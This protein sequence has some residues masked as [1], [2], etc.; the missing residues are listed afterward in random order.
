MS[1]SPGGSGGRNGRRRERREPAAADGRERS[2]RR[3]RV[4]RAGVQRTGWRRGASALP[5]P[6][7]VSPRA[8]GRWCVR[9]GGRQEIIRCS[10]AADHEQR[11]RTPADRIPLARRRCRRLRAPLAAAGHRAARERRTAR[12]S[13]A[14]GRRAAR[15][16]PAPSSLGPRVRIGLQH[17]LEQR[18]DAQVD[19]AEIGHLA[20]LLDRPRPGCRPCRS[21][22]RSALRPA[23]GRGCRCRT[24]P[25]R[26]RRTG[27]AARARHSCTCRQ[28]R[29]R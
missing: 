6:E 1:N 24:S 26:R 27:R 9:R 21:A 19:R 28:S 17:L 29:C 20:A 12:R 4:A 16:R 8:G 23:P 7:T 18:P 5:A 15:R 3:R 14:S 22:G 13:G 25:S 10:R 2:E 11:T